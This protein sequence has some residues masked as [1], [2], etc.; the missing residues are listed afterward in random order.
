[1]SFCLIV[2]LFFFYGCNNSG[3]NNGQVCKYFENVS[4]YRKNLFVCKNANYLV[5]LTS[6]ERESD[7]AMNGVKSNLVDFGVVTVKFEKAFAGSK[8]QFELKIDKDTYTGEFEINPYDNTFVYD[9]GKQVSDSSSV[10]LYLVDIDEKINLECL[11]KDWKVNYKQAL[12]VFEDKHEKE[13]AESLKDKKLQ[14]E[15]YIKTVAEDANLNDIYWYIML[16]TE[17]GEMYASLISV[18]TGQIMQ[19]S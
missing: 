13:I 4:E 3:G 6:G 9:I 1:M 5:T 14:G 15:I 18:T 7:Y 8:L 10:S 19:N 11:S 16:I 2:S 17:N 12:K